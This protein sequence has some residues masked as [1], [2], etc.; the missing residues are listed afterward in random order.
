MG[1]QSRTSSGLCCMKMECAFPFHLLQSLSR[2]RVCD[3][4]TSAVHPA[5]GRSELDELRWDS[6]IGAMAFGLT[7]A[8]F[9][10]LCE[11]TSAFVLCFIVQRY[12][13]HVLDPQWPHPGLFTSV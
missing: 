11:L 9:G 8:N 10:S 3:A 12:A 7:G 2:R 5:D 4:A 1:R 13:S 6:D